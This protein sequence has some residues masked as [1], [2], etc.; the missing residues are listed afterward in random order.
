VWACV[1]AADA[2]IPDN[3]SSPNQTASADKANLSDPACDGVVLDRTAPTAAIAASATSVKTGD[4]VSFQAQATDATSGVAAQSAWTW[5]DNTAGG[6]GPSATHTFTQAGTYE[7]HLTVAD[8]AGNTATA[9]KVITVAAPSG[10]GAPTT[11]GGGTPTTTGGGGTP[12]TTG[13]GTPT[14]TGG[15]TAAPKLA[16]SAPRKLA[17][18]AKAVR[19]A[20]TADAAGRV[21]LALLRGGRVVSRGGVAVSA[22]TSSYALKL[23]KGTKAGRYAIKAT[24]TPASGAPRTAGRTITLT[25]KPAARRARIASRPGATVG[26]GPV[27]LPDGAFH[28]PR[29]ART[30]AV[31]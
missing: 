19:V 5:G 27:A 24:Y 12:T 31:R 7:V 1:R 18:K 26:R 9:T 10:G 22:G 20:L 16:L 30:F 28:G 15:G 13:G 14:T 17:A 2:A 25:G 23:P 29:P 11:T 3:P 6:S 8:T 4:L 21:Q